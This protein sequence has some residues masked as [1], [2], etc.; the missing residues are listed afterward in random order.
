MDIRQ[1]RILAAKNYLTI[2]GIARLMG[3]TKQAIYAKLK[4]P[5][6]VWSERSQEIFSKLE[7][8]E[9][10]KGTED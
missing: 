2:P 7:A 10:V 1:L 6:S 3:I 9:Y 5:N 4:N 8:L